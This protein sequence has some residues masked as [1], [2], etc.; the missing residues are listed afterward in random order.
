MGQLFARV[1]SDSKQFSVDFFGRDATSQDLEGFDSIVVATPGSTV[2]HV[3]RLLK[4]STSN[5]L[6]ICLWSYMGSG[7]EAFNDL[8]LSVVYIHLLFGPD[9]EDLNQQNIVVAGDHEDERFGSIIKKL[10]STGANVHYSSSEEHDKAMAY[11]QS[12]SQLSS[13][14]L[15]ISLADSGY[16]RQQLN[17][18]ASLTFR[19]NRYT[20]ER[21]MRQK[22]ELW[23]ELQFENQ[24]YPQVLHQYLENLRKM[25]AAIEAK[26]YEVFATLFNGAVNF[27]EVSV[28][29]IQVPAPFKDQ[30]SLAGKLAAL[31]PS[32]T[33]SHEAALTYDAQTEVALADNI[34]EV[35]RVVAEGQVKQGII[36]IENSIQGVVAES[37]DGLFS[38]NL[39]IIDEV[40]L[41]INHV[42]CA[43]EPPQQKD[44]IKVIYSHPQALGQCRQYLRREYPGA[45]LVPTV[46]TAAA[47]QKIADQKALN[48]LAIGPKF[49]AKLYGLTVLEEGIQDA[50]GNQTRFV[51]FE[52]SPLHAKTRFTQIVMM[53]KQDRPGLLRDI[54]NVIQEHDVNMSQIE[55]RPDRTKLG[56]YIF[57]VRLDITSDDTRLSAII[58]QLNS[59]N[60]KTRKLTP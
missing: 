38:S 13:I 23:A 40:V 50:P 35:I 17:D 56:S 7:T 27:W 8:A 34:S 29:E 10:E 19:L 28:D 42:L 15:G 55:S 18:F 24:Y 54:L 9:I 47:M 59:I 2:E 33:Y 5:P 21:I 11:T 46:S 51:V 25:V 53:P 37:L 4:E 39:T 60:V 12:M 44:L 20:I 57:Y 45:V 3:N 1:I 6:I 14:M 52:K 32:G 41:D 31:G 22:A 30:A 48:A 58:D 26:D 43:L 16:S 49:A 36:P